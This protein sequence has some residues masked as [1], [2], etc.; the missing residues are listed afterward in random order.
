MENRVVVHNSIKVED[1]H[2]RHSSTYNQTDSGNLTSQIFANFYMDTFDHYVKHDLGIRYYG[3]YVD[4]FIIVH[5]DKA[6]LKDLISTLGNF[7]DKELHLT[8][9]PKKIYLQHYSKGVS[10][11]GTIIKPGRIYIGKRTKGNF[12]QAVRKQNTIV[13]TGKPSQ[14]EQVAFQSSMNS[15][16]GIMKH[17]NTYKLR[18]RLLWK[19][20][21]AYWWNHVYLSGGYAKFV[22]KKKGGK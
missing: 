22:L 21:S 19:N 9:H 6:Y 18:K 1:C 14:Q 20:L 11:L 10:F 17:Y 15:Y 13:K 12:Y 5:E 4:D 16:L 8:L 7:L 3:R 2:T